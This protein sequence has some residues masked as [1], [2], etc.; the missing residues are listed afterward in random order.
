[1]MTGAPA[2]EY[3]A[4][5]SRCPLVMSRKGL[6]TRD[7]HREL[8]GSAA[9]FYRRP[10]MAQQSAPVYIRFFVRDLRN[11]WPL[12]KNTCDGS[13]AH[14]HYAGPTVFTIGSA[15]VHQKGPACQGRAPNYFW[16]SILILLVNRGIERCHDGDK[17]ISTRSISELDKSTS[18]ASCFDLPAN[19]CRVPEISICGIALDS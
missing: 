18:L 1:M 9:S 19:C 5:S 14:L 4:P 3:R 10:A 6:S 16:T 11:G 12:T 17:V 13:G 7:Q 15:R 2:F 8:I